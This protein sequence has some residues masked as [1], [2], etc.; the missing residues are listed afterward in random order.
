MKGLA[1]GKPVAD[2][3]YRYTFH[4]PFRVY[5][6][7]E[8]YNAQAIAREVEGLAAGKLVA[9]RPL[10]VHVARSVPCLLIFVEYFTTYAIACEVEGL[11]A[12]N[13]VADRQYRYTCSQFAKL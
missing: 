1:A 3:H 9:D 2:R 8:Y 6:F 4:G 10:Q 13:L 5:I 12:G 11:S 7:A